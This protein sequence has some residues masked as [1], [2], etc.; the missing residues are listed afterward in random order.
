MS[1]RRR[2]PA[3]GA[4]FAA[5]GLLVA[6]LGPGASS[7]AGAAYDRFYAN[8]QGEELMRAI[9]AD[10]EAVGLAPFHA[11]PGLAAIARDR[12][13][14]CPTKPGLTIRGRARDMADRDYLSHDV[15]G[16]QKPGGGAF[17]T[18]DLLAAFGVTWS[19]AG[20][21]L[22]TNNFPSTKVDYA[23]GCSSSGGSCHGSIALPRSV[24]VAERGW[25]SSSTH[26]N[27]VLSTTF[28]R[29]GCAAWNGTENHHVYACYFMAGGDVSSDGT[30][31]AVS[32]TSGEGDAFAAGSSPKFTATV[33][34]GASLLADGRVLLDGAVI[35]SWAHDHDG[36]TESLSVVT[37]HLA[38]GHHTL[39][40]WVRDTSMNV[41]SVD[42]EFTVKGRATATPKPSAHDKPTPRLE[43]DAPTASHGQAEPSAGADSNSPS[44]SATEPAGQGSPEASDQTAF[45]PGQA[46]AEPIG[47]GAGDGAALDRGRTA[48]GQSGG[49]DGGWLLP[50]LVA[51]ALLGTGILAGRRQP[52]ADRRRPGGG[53]AE[54]TV[55]EAG[56]GP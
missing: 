55:T 23:T 41:R 31:P 2:L 7:V 44:A 4:A 3:L 19:N 6:G 11:D 22:S 39:T 49:A 40:W 37:S 48:L 8:F 21:N 17:G 46:T 18:F 56:E 15:Q 12:S 38:A 13:H 51:L 24:A 1:V 36:S 16:C 5:L 47:D 42:V 25:M 34:D 35:K 50:V 14:V 54:P 30:G 28:K 27:L 45:A 26:R 10:R 43:T 32:Q 9:N 20:E 29:F 52:G 53:I 33:S